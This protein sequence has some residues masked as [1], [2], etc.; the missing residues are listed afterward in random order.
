MKPLRVSIVTP[1]LNRRRQ[2]EGAIACIRNQTYPHIEHVIVDGGSTDGTLDVLKSHED[3]ERITW[4]SEPD[5]GVYAA[6]NKG[7]DLATGDIVAYLNTDDRYFAYSVSVAVE[8]FLRQTGVG[9]V[10]GDLLRFHLESRTGEIN[11]YPPFTRGF[12]SRANL[13]SQP[14][15]FLRRSVIQDIGPFDETVRLA[16]DIDY[17][18]RAAQRHRGLKINDVL[19]FETFHQGR[20]TSGTQ[21]TAV[22]HE[23][24]AVI[25][26]RYAA[27]GTS[28]RIARAL[29]RTRSAFWDRAL[30]VAFIM[31]L[32]FPARTRGWRNF[33]EMPFAVSEKSL[34]WTLLPV[35]G[36]AHRS[37]VCSIRSLP[38]PELEEL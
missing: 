31:S 12:L 28:L 30:R 37:Q 13:I 26:R 19:A 10:Y 5:D 18:A 25:R 23:E 7:L 38:W 20:L 2:L 34:W 16:A 3:D 32:R 11:F 4:V 8:A 22:A 24:L 15:V 35:V 6:V 29:D 27:K 9:F 36:R 14:T 33:R 17:W 21:A 1:S